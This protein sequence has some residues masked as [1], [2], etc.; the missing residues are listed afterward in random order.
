MWYVI[1]CATSPRVV[2][3]STE[4]E[5]EADDVLARFVAQNGVV[6]VKAEGPA[7]GTVAAAA[8]ASLAALGAT[9]PANIAAA[10]NQLSRVLFSQDGGRTWHD[11]SSQAAEHNATEVAAARARDTRERHA[12]VLKTPAFLV[13]EEHDKCACG[14][15]REA[16]VHSV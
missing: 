9:L 12:F 4:D 7:P 16:D 3:V 5:S 2:V 14:E 15:E 1:D 13:G 11:S 10:P 6:C 8:T